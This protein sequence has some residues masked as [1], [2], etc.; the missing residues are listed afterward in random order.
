MLAETFT[1]LNNF[2]ATLSVFLQKNFSHPSLDSF[3]LAVTD[4]HKQ[5]V[6]LSLV[7]LPLILWWL[8]RERK[9]AAM[10][11]LG[12]VF[13]FLLIDGFCGQVIKKVFARERPF[14]LFPEILQ[15]SPASGFSFVSNHAANMAGL[16]FFMS[17]YYPRWRWL[18]WSL[19]VLVAASRVYNG[20]HFFTDVVAGAVIGVLMS[21]FVTS[22]LDRYLKLEKR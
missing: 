13:N 5:A 3:F 14:V 8:W 18:W 10:K 9:A 4:L 20:V 11:L 15:K 2:D 16:A 19:A 6:F 12:L 21:W 1:G 7:V 22:R 17:H